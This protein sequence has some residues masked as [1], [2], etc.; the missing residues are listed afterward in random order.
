MSCDTKAQA[1]VAE[2][3]G[4]LAR[5]GQVT[6]PVVDPDIRIGEYAA[7][8]LKECA[9]RNIAPKTVTRYESSLRL[10]LV[11]RLGRLKVRE[12]TRAVVKDLLVGKLED[13]AASFQGQRKPNLGRRKLA[14]GSVNNLLLTLS[15]LMTQAM[16]DGLVVPNPLQRLGRRLNLGTKRDKS[17]PKAFDVDQLHQFLS[18]AREHEPEMLPAFALMAYAG[19]RVGEAIALQWDR[20]DLKG[21]RLVVD[22]QLLGG[23]KTERRAGWWT[24][25]TLS[26]TFCVGSIVVSGRPASGMAPPP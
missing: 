26:G 22:R 13:E 11:P 24:W 14:R 10:H 3:E 2:A 7:R 5:T 21:Q 9:A 19:L 17:K 4:K 25:P 23:L 16:E 6:V 15:S 1:E 8:F 18:T 20:V 12:L